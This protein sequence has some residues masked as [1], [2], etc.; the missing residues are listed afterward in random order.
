MITEEEIKEKII[1]ALSEE[2]ELEPE[3]LRPS[4]TLYEEL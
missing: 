2:F 1:S 4:A 3:K